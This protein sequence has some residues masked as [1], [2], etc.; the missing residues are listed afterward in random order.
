M[1]VAIP[2]F[3]SL[4]RHPAGGDPVGGFACPPPPCVVGAL[5]YFSL[6]PE[7]I[8][9]L[10]SFPRMIVITACSSTGFRREDPGGLDWR[11]VR[12]TGRI[13]GSLCRHPADDGWKALLC[14]LDPATT[15]R[16]RKLQRS[17]SG[18]IVREGANPCAMVAQG[19]ATEPRW[20]PAG[21]AASRAHRLQHGS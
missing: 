16:H 13:A 17:T 11:L 18:C 14:E 20:T 7:R 2:M 19:A 3:E 6:S 1:L 5:V 21:H 9:F 10:P 4:P 12:A 8:G 15:G